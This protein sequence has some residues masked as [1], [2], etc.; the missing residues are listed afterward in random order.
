MKTVQSYLRNADKVSLLGQLAYDMLGDRIHLLELKNKSIEDIQIAYKD[1]MS[2]FIDHL[3]TIDAIPAENMV[4]YLSEAT[5]FDKQMNNEYVSLHLV[6]LNEINEN[7][8]AS[9]YAFEMTDWGKALGYLV[10]DNE[11]TQK[12]I[13][14]LLTLFLREISFF[15]TDP[16]KHKIRVEKLHADLERSIKEI[17][18]GKT[19]K[20]YS[21]E[22]VFGKSD[23]PID[24]TH[25][26][27]EIEMKKAE[28]KY[29]RYSCWHERSIILKNIGKTAPTFEEAEKIENKTC[30][31]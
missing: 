7:I 30:N 12:R 6:D 14:E 15:G 8:Y 18:E 13:I 26:M 31:K 5:A 17:K 20:T 4:L 16:E 25:R 19:G 24:E 9:S 10:A 23:F 21:A 3:L 11:L 27:L 29:D 1:S 2:E 22:E 28:Y